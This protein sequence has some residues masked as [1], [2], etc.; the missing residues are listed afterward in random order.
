M[1]R[2]AKQKIIIFTIIIAITSIVLIGILTA[3]S[4]SPS[5][6]GGPQS[7]IT[8]TLAGL[9]IQMDK[10]VNIKGSFYRNLS[11]SLP[12]GV[13]E[14]YVILWSNG[15]SG[16]VYAIDPNSH[17]MLTIQDDIGNNYVTRGATFSDPPLLVIVAGNWNLEFSIRGYGNVHYL[18]AYKE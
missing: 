9:T 1:R 15:T 14:I 11:F 5:G 18:L 8:P 6:N 17:Q 12:S 7:P 16:N 13:S 10:T 2:H 3:R 4:N